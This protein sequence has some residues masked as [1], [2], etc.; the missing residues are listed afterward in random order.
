[1]PV[2]VKKTLP[3]AEPVVVDPARNGVL[4]RISPVTDH[5]KPD[6]INIFGASGSGKTTLACTWPKPLLLI[7]AEDGTKSITDVKGVDF[8]RLKESCE[9]QQLFDHVIAKG[10]ARCMP[11]PYATVVVDTVTSYQ[12]L[13]LK[14]VLGLDKIPHSKT[15]G[16][17]TLD[18]YGQSSIMTKAMI[19]GAVDLAETHKLCHVLLLTQE[20]NMNEGKESELLKPRITA[21][22]T[23]SV[24]AYFNP[25]CDYLLQTFQVQEEKETKTEINGQV[26]IQMEKTN[27]VRFCLRT[28]PHPVYN[29][30]FRGPKGKELPEYIFDPTYEKVHALMGDKNV[31]ERR[32]G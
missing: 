29:I 16:M 7:G 9:I 32:Q 17:A 15:W 30:K 18:Q 3:P 25:T 31:Q 2:S 26:V 6:I 12:G 24:L 1:M 27:R 19:Q 21:A 23:K 8:V 4:A 5:K 22:L 28:C 14:E 13:T 20:G 11:G 10:R